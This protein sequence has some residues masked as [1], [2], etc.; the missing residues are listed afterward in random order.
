MTAILREAHSLH[1][2]NVSTENRGE[3]WVSDSPA[4]VMDSSSQSAESLEDDAVHKAHV[5]KD[6]IAFC[7]STPRRS[8]SYRQGFVG[9][10]PPGN[11]SR[12]MQ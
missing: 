9:L 12:I 1:K 6:F 5:E 4:A 3:T 11:E 8:S 7:S 2:V 10:W